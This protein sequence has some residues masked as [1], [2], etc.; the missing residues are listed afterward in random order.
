[1]N[2]ATQAF[3]LCSKRTC[4][5]KTL[6][7]TST[8]ILSV[9]ARVREGLSSCARRRQERNHTVCSRS[10]QVVLSFTPET[11]LEQLVR[12]IVRIQTLICAF[13]DESTEPNTGEV[14]CPKLISQRCQG[15]DVLEASV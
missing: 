14:L 6:Q 12:C 11:V 5:T 13:V 8:T 15:A 1:M 4:Q 10:V 3:L 7:S 9:L 2:I